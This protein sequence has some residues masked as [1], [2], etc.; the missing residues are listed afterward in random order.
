MPVATMDPVST[1][2]LLAMHGYDAGEGEGEEGELDP[3][4]STNAEL[5]ELRDALQMIEDRARENLR[6]GKPLQE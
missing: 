6:Q 2:D 3:E 5:E 4:E 1:D